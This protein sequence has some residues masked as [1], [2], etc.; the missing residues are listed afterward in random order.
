MLLLNESIVRRV[1]PLQDLIGAMEGALAQFSSGEAQQPLR[2]VMQVGKDRSWFGI[3]SAYVPSPE[4]LGTKLVTVF[5]RN[6]ERDLPTHMA[7]IV[8]LDPETGAP[9][10]VLD[11]RYI[12]EARTAAVSAVSAKHLGSDGDVAVIGS[13]VQAR[14]HLEALP[15]VRRIG[16]ARVWSP[17]PE[18]REQFASDMHGHVPCSVRACDSAE[19]AV[20]GAALIVLATAAASPVVMDDW[21]APGAHVMAVG[22][23]RPDQREMDPQLVHRARLYVDSRTA[24][25]AESGDV[26]LAIED[27][28]IDRHHIVAELG[29]AVAGTRP[30]RASRDEITIFKSLGMAVEDVAAARLAYR[31][32]VDERLGQPFDISA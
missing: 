32:A 20:R 22:A 4:A 29:E 27:G 12:T 16:E 15:L 9:L 1:L 21:V 5:A 24:A 3:M 30:G 25:L 2:T 19:Q 18:H 26:L 28:L 17:T 14:S 8:L 31:R 7:A 23:C 11:G 10:A 13:G 6:R